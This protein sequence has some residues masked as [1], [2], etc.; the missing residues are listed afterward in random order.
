[1]KIKSRPDSNGSNKLPSRFQINDKVL[2]QGYPVVVHGVQF[3]FGKVNYIVDR[4]DSFP[5]LADSVDVDA[6]CAASKAPAGWS[7]TRVHGHTGPCAAVEI[8]KPMSRVDTIL[9][10]LRLRSKGDV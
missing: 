8:E 3:T 7:C 4:G 2:Y 9:S 5:V 1:M 10:L 6:V